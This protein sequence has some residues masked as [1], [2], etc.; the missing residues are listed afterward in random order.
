M[1]ALS[2]IV[3]ILNIATVFCTIVRVT[4]VQFLSN[5]LMNKDKINKFKQAF[6][7]LLRK[8][9][10]S[11][12]ITQEELAFRADVAVR[13]IGHLEGGERQPTIAV[14]C[15]L[16]YALDTTPDMFMKELQQTLSFLNNEQS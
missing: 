6:A 16:A 9:R 5:V 4:I 3:H 1:P 15:A 12:Q 10:N 14:F 2:T 11:L 7:T 13:Y 8:K